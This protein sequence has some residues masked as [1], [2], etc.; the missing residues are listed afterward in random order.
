MNE[1]AIVFGAA[2]EAPSQLGE[3][4]LFNRTARV[5]VGLFLVLEHSHRNRDE[6]HL[7]ANLKLF[8]CFV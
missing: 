5:P 8:F 2:L 3:N 4:Q 7:K 6:I 1:T